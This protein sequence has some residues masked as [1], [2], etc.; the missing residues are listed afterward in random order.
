MLQGIS[1][2]NKTPER[3]NGY[4]I[5]HYNEIKL[6]RVYNLAQMPNKINHLVVMVI[7]MYNWIIEAIQG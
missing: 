1:K 2:E 4:P 6:Y 5:G 7:L 3:C